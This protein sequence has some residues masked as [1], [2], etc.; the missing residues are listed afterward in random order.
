ME[1]AKLPHESKHRQQHPESKQH[2]NSYFFLQ[3]AVRTVHV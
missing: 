1:V 2:S 3:V